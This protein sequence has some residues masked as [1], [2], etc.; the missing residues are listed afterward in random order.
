MTPKSLRSSRI[1][2]RVSP[3]ERALCEAKAEAAGLSVSQLIRDHLGRVKV[4][5]REDR[6]ALTREI[7][8]IGSNLNQLAHWVNTYKHTTEALLVLRVLRDLRAELGALLEGE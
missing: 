7:A 4:V 1:Y 3:E 2:V 8:R 5:N 6:R